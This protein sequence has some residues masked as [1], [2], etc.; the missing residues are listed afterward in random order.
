MR[1]VVGAGQMVL[2]RPTL[3]TH[4]EERRRLVTEPPLI[5]AAVDEFLPA[6]AGRRHV[7]RRQTTR[8]GSGGKRGREA[9]PWSSHAARHPTSPPPR[10][11]ALVT[12][13]TRFSGAETTP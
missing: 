13:V 7:R 1:S 6:C 5:F 10:F 8:S 4:A 12:V 3:V 2:S 11:F 9:G